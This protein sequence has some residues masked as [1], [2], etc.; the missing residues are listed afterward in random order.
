MQII[1]L[2][3]T[4]THVG[5]QNLKKVFK[6]SLFVPYFAINI[7]YSKGEALNATQ[8]AIFYY[9]HRDLTQ[10]YTMKTFESC[11]L[12]FVMKLGMYLW[13]KRGLI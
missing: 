11:D 10:A 2:F 7:C 4:V 1:S 13:K 3:S 5:L 12:L 8:I 9:V 6:N